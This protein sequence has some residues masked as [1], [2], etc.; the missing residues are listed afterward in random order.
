MSAEHQAAQPP[1]RLRRGARLP[2]RRRVAPSSVRRATAAPRRPRARRRRDETQGLLGISPPAWRRR[3]TPPAARRGGTRRRCWRWRRPWVRACERSGA[4]ARE[5]FQGSR[6]PATDARRRRGARAPRG[7][8]RQAAAAAGALR[9]SSRAIRARSVRAVAL[10][11]GTAFCEAAP[12]PSVARR[13]RCS[14][15]SSGC[16]AQQPAP[17]RRRAAASRRDGRLRRCLERQLRVTARRACSAPRRR[18]LAARLLR[19]RAGAAC[20]RRLRRARGQLGAHG[21]GRRARRSAGRATPRAPPRAARPA[22]SAARRSSRGGH[23]VGRRLSGR[24][25]GFRTH[26]PSDGPDG[27]V[28]GRRAAHLATAGRPPG[29]AAG[30]GGVEAHAGAAVR[31]LC[32]P[33]RRWRAAAHGATAAALT[34]RR[35]QRPHLPLLPAHLPVGAAQAGGAPRGSRR[36]RRGPRSGGASSVFSAQPW[37]LVAQLAARRLA[38]ARP[39]AAARRRWWGS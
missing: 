18:R 32:A 19:R 5:V 33:G 39:R 12:F 21:A 11:K 9:G 14:Q 31:L 27:G 1:K 10:R 8:R 25:R 4:T 6:K 26:R 23:G 2:P 29:Q 38:S 30:P 20:A 37:A 13:L 35:A 34:L 15:R 16:R 17:S 28:C 7:S 36:P 22:R 3:P 24:L